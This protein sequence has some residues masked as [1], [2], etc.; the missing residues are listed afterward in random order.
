MDISPSTVIVITGASSGIG[1]A[2]AEE[3]SS[4]GCKLALCAR[5]KARLDAVARSA[6]ENGAAVYVA[7]CDISNDEA[8]RAFIE[9]VIREFGTVDVLINNAGRGNCASVEHTTRERLHSVFELNVFSLWSTTAAV[10]PLM[11]AQQGGH[12]ITISS[13]AGKVGYPFNSAYVAA[14]H[15]AVGFMASLRAEL[16]DTGVRAT[17]VCPA[18]VTTEWSNV[19]EDA[20]IGALFGEGIKRSRS[21]ARERG[22]PLPPLKPMMSATDAARRI[23]DVVRNDEENDVYTHEGSEESAIHCATNRSSFEA[24]NKALY[25]GMQ[26]AYAQQH[27]A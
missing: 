14:K 26:Q 1:A 8:A 11:K 7:E 6:R 16:V 20:S 15:A 25:I 5:R 21:I 12:I 13:V 4:F 2:L 22:L 24:E 19:S 23:I 3:L 9:N 18:G 17:V 10:L 27:S